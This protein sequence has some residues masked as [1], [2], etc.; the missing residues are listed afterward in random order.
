MNLLIIKLR[1]SIKWGR[2]HFMNHLV[3]FQNFYF[4]P[5]HEAGSGWGIPTPPTS[6]GRV[7]F[8]AITSIEPIIYFTFTIPT[9]I[10]ILR[11]DCHAKFH[12]KFLN[13]CKKLFWKKLGFF[14]TLPFKRYENV[15]PT[16][17]SYIAMNPKHLDLATKELVKLQSEELV[18]PTT[19]QWACQAFY[20]N[21]R[22]EQIK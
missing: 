16:K 15:N 17:V 6:L 18:E 4:S 21:K 13:K 14:I 5:L 12:T 9:I 19:S 2:H 8:L 7:G 11:K 22:S 1:K 3:K 10:E 20:A